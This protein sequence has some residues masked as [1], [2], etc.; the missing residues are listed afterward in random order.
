M[1][2]QHPSSLPTSEPPLLKRLRVELLVRIACVTSLVSLALMS[3]SLLDPTPLPVM[4]SM[5][6]GQAIGALALAF[7]LLAV[8]LYQLR[9]R[10]QRR[11]STPS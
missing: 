11:S 6:V 9:L 7:Y 4:V 8:L 3:W 1:T 5:S 10:K 2:T